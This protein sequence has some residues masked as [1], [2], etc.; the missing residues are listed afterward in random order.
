MQIK[1]DTWTQARKHIKSLCPPLQIPG[2]LIEL[3]LPLWHWDTKKGKERC[4]VP[5]LLLIG[6]LILVEVLAILL[7]LFFLSLRFLNIR[8]GPAMRRTGDLFK[9]LP[10]HQTL[11]VPSI[12][13]QG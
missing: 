1:Q 5:K 10:V 8:G 6:V 12:I 2:N 11:G 4:Y 3:L 13:G 9:V 7:L